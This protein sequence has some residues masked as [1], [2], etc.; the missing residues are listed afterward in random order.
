MSDWKLLAKARAASRL[1]TLQSETYR[2]NDLLSFNQKM[3]ARDM[4]VRTAMKKNH[5]AIPQRVLIKSE[6]E[7]ATAEKPQEK[8]G[9]LSFIGLA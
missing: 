7:I 4:C 5:A 9:W 8:K 1:R 2:A 3:Q 6:D